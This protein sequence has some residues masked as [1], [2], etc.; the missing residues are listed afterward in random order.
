[1]NKTP[2]VRKS[3]FSK[4]FL[5]FS[6]ACLGLISYGVYIY[7][8]DMNSPV[9]IPASTPLVPFD[10]SDVAKED[11]VVDN[12]QSLDVETEHRVKTN[13]ANEELLQNEEI[14]PLL[15]GSIDLNITFNAYNPVSRTFNTGI[16]ITND[17]LMTADSCSLEIKDPTGEKATQKTNVVGWQGVSGC[18]FNNLDL[19]SLPAPN[20]VNHWTITIE[21]TNN[22]NLKLATLERDISSL[23]SL[24]T[25]LIN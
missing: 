23:D 10:D 12:F 21:A 14:N 20:D 18:R 11:P 7:I 6:L 15:I 1:M 24:N 13:L 5:A 8:K 19:S 22:N 9:V 3:F 25:L 4:L 16:T 17:P 2:P